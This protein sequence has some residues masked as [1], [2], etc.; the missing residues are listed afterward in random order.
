MK[1]RNVLIAVAAVTAVIIGWWHFDSK[2]NYVMHKAV[3]K[4]EL[5]AQRVHLVTYTTATFYYQGPTWSV[6]SCTTVYPPPSRTCVNGSETGSITVNIPPGYYGTLTLSS[7]ELLSWQITAGSIGAISNLTYTE[8][9]SSL[10]F[11]FEDGV[12]VQGPGGSAWE[13]E[14][15]P[16]AYSLFIESNSV[17]KA[18]YIPLPSGDEVIGY[19]ATPPYGVW[20]ATPP[21]PPNLAKML[22]PSC[23]VPGGVGCGDP[24]T[25][26]N[27]NVF[28]QDDGYSTI[29]QNPLSFSRYYNSLSASGVYAATLG[30]NWRHSFDRYLHI[31]SSSSVIAERAT[32]Q[33]VSFSSSGSWAPD[34][35]MD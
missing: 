21:T 12:P 34:T 15:N 10:E 25:L 22:G 23:D 5:V 4:T 24:I 31:V 3:S 30:T 7:T 32:G 20:S 18:D 14:R 29:G 1:L 33:E 28:E 27:G 13:L 6:P 2:T 8:P 19:I 17:E 35:D 26:S 9:G 16:S 11:V